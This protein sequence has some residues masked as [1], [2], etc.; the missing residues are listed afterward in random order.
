MHLL[1]VSKLTFI[2]VALSLFSCKPKNTDSQQTVE[3]S[4]IDSLYV[5]EAP[6]EDNTNQIVTKEASTQEST[7]DDVNDAAFKT[8]EKNILDGYNNSSF[9]NQLKDC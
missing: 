5:V 7:H 9:K 3:T 4:Y 1:N 8:F 2:I 6:T